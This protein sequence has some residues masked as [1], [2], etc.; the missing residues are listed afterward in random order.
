MRSSSAGRVKQC[1]GFRLCE[2]SFMETL[3]RAAVT[4]SCGERGATRWRP[5]WRARSSSNGIGIPDAGRWSWRRIAR[6]R[7]APGRA[8]RQQRLMRPRYGQNALRRFSGAPAQPSIARSWCHRAPARSATTRRWAAPGG[9]YIA[10]FQQHGHEPRRGRPMSWSR[11][12]SAGVPLSGTHT[13]Q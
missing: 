8:W 6:H 10:L 11:S 12:P 7:P 3:L 2:R 13:N 5:D 1:I 4:L 9:R